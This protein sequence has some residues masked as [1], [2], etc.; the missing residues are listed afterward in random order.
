MT[1]PSALQPTDVRQPDTVP[2]VPTRAAV[3]LAIIVE[4]DCS[5]EDANVFYD[6]WTD[7]VMP[8][9]RASSEQR[10]FL[11]QD[12]LDDPRKHGILDS[13][14]PDGTS[15]SPG[16]AMSAV[17][18]STL[19][20]EGGELGILHGKATVFSQTYCQVTVRTVGFTV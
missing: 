1:Q 20:F 6:W 4:T 5:E 19:N 17:E 14:A 3:I 16:S 10:Y 18:Q 8:A 7:E 12:A 9:L 15:S 2:D 13:I 11:P